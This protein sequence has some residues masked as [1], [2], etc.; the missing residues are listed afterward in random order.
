[1]YPPRSMTPSQAT[2]KQCPC[3]PSPK[4]HEY[5]ITNE[6]LLCNCWSPT[7]SNQQYTR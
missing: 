1:M 2:G 3:A 6:S 5:M 4:A 7:P